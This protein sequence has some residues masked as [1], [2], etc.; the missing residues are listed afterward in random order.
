MTS[1]E[2]QI[3][4]FLN[5]EGWQNAIRHKIPGDASARR[6]ERL[7]KADGYQAILMDAPP[8]KEDVKPFIDI[9]ELLLKNQ[10]HAPKILA[11]DTQEGFLILEDL[12]DNSFTRILAGNSPI[13]QESDEQTLYLAA[14][15]VLIELHKYPPPQSIPAY[16][17]ELLMRE[18]KLLTEWYLPLAIREKSAQYNEE[19]EA[20]WDELFQHETLQ[21][22]V[23]VLRDYHADNLMWLPEAKGTQRVG[24]LDFQDAVIGSPAYDILSLLEDARRDVRSETVNTCI[25]H[26]LKAVPQI[27]EE[28]FKTAYAILAAQRNC[29]IIGIFARLAIRDQKMRY[30]E[31]IPRVWGHLERD[32]T[33]PAVKKLRDWITTTLPIETRHIHN[34]NNHN[35]L[36]D[37]VQT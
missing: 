22:S 8:P 21:Q 25:D 30:L 11:K 28:Q 3:L 5:K 9:A 35:E 36:L 17:Y 6:Y 27:D 1:R 14:I 37:Y 10:L 29:K 31:Y 4:E 2:T 12:G 15:D 13:S 33:H 26:Y 20:L 16:S 18:A 34:F 19:Y 23:I 24:L 7:K 32:L